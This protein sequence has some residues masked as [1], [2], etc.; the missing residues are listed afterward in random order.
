MIDELKDVNIWIS[1]ISDTSIPGVY[2]ISVKIRA[3]STIK[4]IEFDLKH[5]PY[6]YLDNVYSDKTEVLY[7]GSYPDLINDISVYPCDNT[8]DNCENG[9]T[10]DDVIILDYHQGIETVID[11][12]GLE[13]FVVQDKTFLVDGNYSNLFLYINHIDADFSEGYSDIY[14]NGLEEDIFLKRIYYNGPDSI[15]IPIG[16]L[17][18][19]FVVKSLIVVIG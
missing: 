7:N 12:D 4:A 17:M 16:G 10:M 6:I 5:L 19:K 14:Y 1:D 18:Q 8:N 15:M 13:D 9:E 3:N 11:F 2:N